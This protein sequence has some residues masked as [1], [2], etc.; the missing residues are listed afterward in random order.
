MSGF[1]ASS[2]TVWTFTVPDQFVDPRTERLGLARRIELPPLLLMATVVAPEEPPRAS[3]YQVPCAT[4]TSIR[5]RPLQPVI[6]LLPVMLCFDGAPLVPRS[7]PPEAE[8]VT[9]LVFVV[10]HQSPGQ[11]CPG[12]SALSP[13]PFSR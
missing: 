9:T 7:G 12:L 3:G 13:L 5:N 4:R 1:P 6:S 11:A 10:G 8:K 2:A